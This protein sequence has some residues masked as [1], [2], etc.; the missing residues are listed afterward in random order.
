VDRIGL[1]DPYS[2]VGIGDVPKNGR[3]WHRLS[4]QARSLG[5]EFPT[6][7]VRFGVGGIP[8]LVAW[9]DAAYPDD[10]DARADNGQPL[11]T[12]TSPLITATPT[13]PST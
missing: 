9:I 5:A 7:M 1:L 8:S 6:G 2:G 11:S 3:E 12:V 10:Q 4:S 13:A